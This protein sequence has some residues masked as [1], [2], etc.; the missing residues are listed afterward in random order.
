[1]ALSSH[2][3]M[4]N[5]KR[6]AGEQAKRPKLAKEMVTWIQLPPA[7]GWAS[8]RTMNVNGDE[9][10]IDLTKPSQERM[11]LTHEAKGH[12]LGQQHG[13]GVIRI[14]EANQLLPTGLRV[15]LRTKEL[16]MGSTTG[17]V[18]WCSNL[19]SV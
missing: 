8:P 16:G 13:N 2:F 1:M 18:W 9:R 3:T 11:Y 4:L 5:T 10:A 7:T 15:P 14:H 17:M 12:R 6:L 19:R